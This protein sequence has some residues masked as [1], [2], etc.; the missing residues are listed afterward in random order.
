MDAPEQPLLLLVQAN[1]APVHEETFNAWYYHHVP[2]LLEIP[3]Y[4][5]SRRYVNVVGD[6]K[7]LALYEISHP[8]VPGVAARSRSGKTR[9]AGQCRT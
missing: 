2:K 5:W 4:Q 6:T 3:G 1:V 7:Y 8:P 9:P